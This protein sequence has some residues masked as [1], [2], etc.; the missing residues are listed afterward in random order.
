MLNSFKHDIPKVESLGLLWFRDPSNIV[1]A[2]TLLTENSVSWTQSDLK[3]QSSTVKS[4]LCQQCSLGHV[5]LY[6]S[7]LCFVFCKMSLIRPI[8]QD[9]EESLEYNSSPVK[10]AIVILNKETTIILLKPNYFILWK[11][12][13]TSK[14]FIHEHQCTRWFPKAHKQSSE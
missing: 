7:E 11:S 5:T 4:Y 9:C 12:L 1:F 3:L 6:L 14:R 2:I 10:M 13:S 8:L